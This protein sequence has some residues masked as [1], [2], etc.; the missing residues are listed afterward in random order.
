MLPEW[1]LCPYNNYHYFFH[2]VDYLDEVNDILFSFASYSQ[3]WSDINMKWNK[4]E[5]G[6]IEDIRMPPSK[7]WKPDV[8]M[9]NRYV[10]YFPGGMYHHMNQLASQG[11]LL[12]YFIYMNFQDYLLDS[13]M[14]IF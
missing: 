9:Y 10:P 4:S 12:T 11:N 5:Y 3:E 13:I 8:L 7:L 14:Y 1:E 2:M 6:N